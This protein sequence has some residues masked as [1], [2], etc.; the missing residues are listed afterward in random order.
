MS[1]AL[2]SIAKNQSAS[3]Y[4]TTVST[5]CELVEKLRSITFSAFLTSLASLSPHSS[6]TSLS[7]SAYTS[8]LKVQFPSSIGRNETEAVIWRNKAWI[9]AWISA[10]VF[11]VD[12]CDVDAS[13]AGAEFSLSVEALRREDFLLSS[14]KMLT[15]GYVS[16]SNFISSL[17]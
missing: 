7:A 16:A 8:T 4:D 10:S 12:D 11:S 13:T 3:L 5:R 17:P 9:S 14:L 15:F 2:K 1:P 6:G